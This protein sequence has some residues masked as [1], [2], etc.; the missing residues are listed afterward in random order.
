MRNR[1]L[2]LPAL[3]AGSIGFSNASEYPK[4]YFGDWTGVAGVM[5][6]D[7]PG[8]ISVLIRTESLNP[9][10]GQ[11][12]KKPVYLFF[13][14]SERES[15]TL[16][17]SEN[18]LFLPDDR[19]CSNGQCIFSQEGSYKLSGEK[20]K[21]VQLLSGSETPT[22]VML[23]MPT[24]KLASKMMSSEYVSLTFKTFKSAPK[25]E[26]AKFKTNGFSDAYFW[27]TQ[28]FANN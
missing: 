15:I 6:G 25:S 16:L 5:E 26:V 20:E 21:P 17:I 19:S 28:Y 2:V 7:K 3:L 23:K 22:A 9:I 4:Q 11:K 18:H 8:D 12:G 13:E 24:F 10:Q 1:A 27:C 14:C